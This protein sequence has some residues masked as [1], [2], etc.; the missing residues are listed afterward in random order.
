MRR[1]GKSALLKNLYKDYLMQEGISEDHIIIV[2]LDLLKYILLR[3][4][5]NL[6][7]FISS[8]IAD[9]KRYYIFIDEIQFVEGFEE[10]ANS[11]KAEFNTDI[12][13]TCSNSKLLSKDI[14]TVFRGRGIEIKVFPLSF[15]ELYQTDKVIK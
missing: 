7:T 6:Y 1:S 13:I 4:A 2:S 3:S 12:Y 14:N 9:R 15:K 5:D 8:Q 11:L 10:V